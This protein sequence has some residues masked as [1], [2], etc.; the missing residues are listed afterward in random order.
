MR[1]VGLLDLNVLQLAIVGEY[2]ERN[3]QL[4]MNLLKSTKFHLTNEQA[5][6]YSCC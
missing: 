4:A 5:I 3:C 1:F 6:P 2:G